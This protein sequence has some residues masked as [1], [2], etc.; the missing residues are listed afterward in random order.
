MKKILLVVFC[1]FCVSQSSYSDKWDG[2]SS[3]T[4]WYNPN[5]NEFHISS[6]SELKGFS[7]LVNSG[8]HTFEGKTVYLEK[9]ID[10]NGKSWI[11]IGYGDD[12]FGNKIFMGVFD[13]NGFKISNLYIKYTELPFMGYMNTVSLFGSSKG[14]ISNLSLTG[15][16]YMDGNNSFSSMDS[17]Y[18]GGIV[19]KGDSLLNCF[20]D[21]NINFLS[22]YHYI[23]GEGICGLAAGEINYAKGIRT[24]G[25][26]YHEYDYDSFANIEAGGLSGKSKEISQC[27]IAGEINIPFDKN[28]LGSSGYIGGIS[29]ISEKIYNSIFVGSLNV[30]N[31]YSGNGYSFVGG[32]CG[33]S[34]NVIISNCIFSP[35]SFECNASMFV[36]S[37]LPVS[38]SSAE[39][40]NTYYLESG[41][42]WSEY[43]GTMISE[44][45]L[46]SGYP[47][48]GYDKQIWSFEND[49]YPMINSLI[50]EYY[51][52]I[53]CE[54]GKMGMIVREGNS[55]A[56]RISP[57]DGW[58]LSTF[59]VDNIDCTSFVENNKYTFN[60]ISSDH[61][62]NVI[63]KSCDETSVM[64]TK[65]SG[66]D[67]EI[68]IVNEG[69]LRVKS[70]GISGYVC[71]YTMDG[72][73]IRKEYLQDTT[74]I[75][76]RSGI[77]IVKVNGESFKVKL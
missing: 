24:S 67:V 56:I 3:D 43:Y 52:Y 64:K 77:Y 70:N 69:L 15:E 58:E 38:D 39:V 73:L 36:G 28:V 22:T 72:K 51:I 66:R 37:I 33:Y 45:D 74:N 47:L 40:N 48:N 42:G 21:V 55:C 31:R 30:I 76:L 50:M 14:I 19:A 29:G 2:I 35:S 61:D 53:P 17:Y 60:N 11:P 8:E 63:L 44:E 34:R 7:D 68:N 18:V 5:E 75:H 54:Y 27:Y 49:K 57:E 65:S 46:K 71:I 41:N 12:Y 23:N 16:I 6:A 26:I 1:I 10:L 59:Y 20:C 25:G 62:I 4:S 9:D 13:G 32:I